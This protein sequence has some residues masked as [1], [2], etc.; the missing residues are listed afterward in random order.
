MTDIERDGDAWVVRLPNTNASAISS[1][2]LRL[3][4]AA[5]G[6]G[7]VFTLVVVCTARTQAKAIEAAVKAG[8]DHP[9]RILVI[10]RSQA[11]ASRIDAEVRASLDVPGSLVICKVSGEALEHTESLV[12]PL[13]LSD[14]PVVVWWPGES[15]EAPSLD[16]LGALGTRVVTDVANSDD[17]MTTL[18]SHARTRDAGS[19]D[20]AWP[21]ITRWRGLLVNALDEVGADVTKAVV[22]AGSRSVPADLMAAWL[23]ARLGCEV[24]RVE[25]T[26]R[27]H[28]C[29]R[30]HTSRGDITLTHDPNG[31][32]LL[33]IPG[34]PDRPVV[35]PFR[36]PN[37]LL[38]EEL[39]HMDVD[40][41]YEETLAAL[42]ARHERGDV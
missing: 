28:I 40:P 19:T 37:E 8:R 32:A 9:S 2:L 31:P 24:E 23:E 25:T 33:S 29:M 22:E 10:V 21:R 4:G 39:R 17:P 13:I 34:Q 20:L 41:V 30:L 14:L 7:L 11:K 3:P 12:V 16:P 42:L 1:A 35:L 38:A 26:H 6:V 27:G 15:P 5:S 36:D 18:L